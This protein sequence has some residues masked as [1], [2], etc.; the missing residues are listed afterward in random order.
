MNDGL[1]CVADSKIDGDAKETQ[2]KYNGSISKEFI[3]VG[4]TQSL[5]GCSA[6]D[7]YIFST[8]RQPFYFQD[9]HREPEPC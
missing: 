4:V 9:G 5:V 7:N 1:Q 2:H 6:S 8:R 3:L